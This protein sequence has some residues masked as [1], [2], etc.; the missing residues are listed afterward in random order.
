MNL[1]YQFQEIFVKFFLF[2]FKKK[3]ILNVRKRKNFTKKVLIYY[4][5]D[6]LVITSLTNTY[7]HTNNW[8]IC[9]MINILDSL[10]FCVDLIDRTCTI[11]DLSFIK[12]EYELFIANSSGGS[13]KLYFHVAEKVPNSIKIFYATGANPQKSYQSMLSRYKYFETRNPMV[14]IEYRRLVKNYDDID[15]F[16]ENVDYIFSVGNDFTNS[17]YNKFNKKIYKIYLST[18][19]K[20]NFFDSRIDLYHRESNNFLFFAGNGNIVKGLDILVESFSIIPEANLFI[21]TNKDNDFFRFY[22]NNFNKCKNIKWIG[23]LNINGSKI[24]KLVLKCP[25]V[26]MPSASEASC[27]SIISS[28]KFGLIPVVTKEVDISSDIGFLIERPEVEYIVELIK[29]LM[30]ISKKKLFEKSKESFMESHKY[31]QESFSNS[32]TKSIIDVLKNKNNYG[33]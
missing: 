7:S 14:N 15:R 21:C 20:I 6:P 3:I 28:M 24:K 12:D 1:F 18:S 33:K 13:G 27:T 29:K 17:T 16:M 25:F 9:K 30:S 10:D 26:I 31:S 32:F 11:K 8:E 19:P 23:F 2:F 4:K 5:T 22:I